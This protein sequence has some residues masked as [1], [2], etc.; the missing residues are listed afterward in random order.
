MAKILD[1][2]WSFGERLMRLAFA[3]DWAQRRR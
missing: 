2:N 1:L 3:F